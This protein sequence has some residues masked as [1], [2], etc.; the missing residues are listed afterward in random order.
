MSH[1]TT[2][3]IDSV[4]PPFV[5]PVVIIADLEGD[6]VDKDNAEFLKTFNPVISH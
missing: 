4:K 1:E 5:T 2:N 6:S 3:S